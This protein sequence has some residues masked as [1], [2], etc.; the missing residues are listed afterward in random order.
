MHIPQFDE[1][2]SGH[3]ASYLGQ[4]CEV[5]HLTSE[6][7]KQLNGRTCQVVGSSNARFE[8]SG[9]GHVGDLGQRSSPAGA[10]ARGGHLSGSHWQRQ[11]A[12]SDACM[13]VLLATAAANSKGA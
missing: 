12:L 7:G 11:R 5:H 13:Y 8:A 10:A 6:T 4:P 3:A 2:W 9:S 1:I